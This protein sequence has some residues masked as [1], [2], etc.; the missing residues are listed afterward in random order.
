M[1]FGLCN[2]PTSFQRCI[3]AIFAYMIEKFIEALMDD[4]LLFGSSFYSC[5][6]N[7]NIV[8]KQCVETHLVLNWEKYHFMVT[9]G[10]VLSHKISHKGIEVD[11][12]KVEVIEKLPPLVNIKGI[13]S[14]LGHARFYKIFIKDFSNIAKPLCNLLIKDTY[15]NFNNDCLSS[16]KI[17]KEKLIYAPIITAH[18][19]KFNFEIMCDVSDYVVESVLGQWKEIMFQVIHY[20]S[21]VLNETQSNYTTTE[22]ELLAIVY[23]L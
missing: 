12:V 1:S 13:R 9:E 20:A 10:I 11:K 22:K 21:K 17:L 6:A 15:F 23:A 8:L 16:F 3:F 4:F 19:W 7:F 14:F 18:D 2:A 5:L